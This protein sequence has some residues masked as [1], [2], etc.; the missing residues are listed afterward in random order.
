MN[1]SISSVFLLLVASVDAL[2]TTTIPPRQ[3][4]VRAVTRKQAALS[5]AAALF[6]V[7]QLPATAEKLTG[8]SDSELAK[9]VTADVVDRQFLATADFT[10]ELFDESATFTDEI[11]TYTLPKFVEGTKKL[12]DATKSRVRLTSPVTVDKDQASFTFSEYLAFNFPIAKPIVSLT[13]KVVLT[14]DRNSGLFTSYREYWDQTPNQVVL[15]AR[16]TPPEN[17]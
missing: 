8:L 17:L 2:S 3:V 11:D 6:F 12:F 13:G 14:R 5:T 15:S 16:L 4:K 7:N 10:R 1:T 9:I